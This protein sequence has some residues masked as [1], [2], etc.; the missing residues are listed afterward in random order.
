MM[1][2]LGIMVTAWGASVK[3]LYIGRG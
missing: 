3:L 1:S 2:L